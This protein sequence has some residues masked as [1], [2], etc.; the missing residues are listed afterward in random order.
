VALLYSNDKQAKKEIRKTTPFTIMT[1]N[2]KYLGVTLN[3]Q[4]KHLYDN[5]FKTQK[6]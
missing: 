6:K 1:N 4:V 3:K 2:K 5:N